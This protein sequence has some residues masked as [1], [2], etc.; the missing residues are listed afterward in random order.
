MRDASSI[1]L[2]GMAIYLSEH[3]GIPTGHIFLQYSNDDYVN[4]RTFQSM[5]AIGISEIGKSKVRYNNYGC[6]KSTDLNTDGS[7]QTYSPLGEKTMMVEVDLWAKTQ[8]ERRLYKNLIEQA[9]FESKFLETHDYGNDPVSGEYMRFNF[10]DYELSDDKPFMASFFM[11]IT[12]PVFKE[13]NAYLA[14]TIL[15]N[16]A[17]GEGLDIV[18]G[19]STANSPWLVITSGGLTVTGEIGTQLD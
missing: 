5:P 1:A 4:E 11:E 7:W 6:T 16:A 9:L 13:Y 15:I 18:D 17:I 3:T 14:D 10:I 19:W 8:A 12:I 2:I